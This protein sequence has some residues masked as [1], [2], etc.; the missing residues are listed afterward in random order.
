MSASFNVAQQIQSKIMKQANFGNLG[1][2]TLS[3]HY[4]IWGV[5]SFTAAPVVK[6]CGYKFAL[7]FGGLSYAL[8]IFGFLLPIER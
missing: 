8:Y 7:I 5:F 4:G 2:Y 3:L 1:F 6:K